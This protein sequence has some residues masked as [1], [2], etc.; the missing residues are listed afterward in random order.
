[1][2]LLAQGDKQG[3]R[4]HFRR[5]VDTGVFD[6]DAYDWSRTFLAR[7]AREPDWPRWIPT[8]QP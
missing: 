4:E 7:M 5:C 6:F 8:H 1:M 3:A 2:S